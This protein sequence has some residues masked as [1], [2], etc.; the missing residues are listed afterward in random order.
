[1][2]LIA[3]RNKVILGSTALTD[4]E[5]DVIVVFELV[6]G[7]TLHDCE[8]GGLVAYDVGDLT[9]PASPCD[10]VCAVIKLDL[11][12]ATPVATE[13]E[14]YRALR[15]FLEDERVDEIVSL[16]L[17]EPNGAMVCPRAWL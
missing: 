15:A 1:M 9:V 8:V 2:I 17:W 6:H 12:D 4:R 5:K 10:Q 13:G 7:C 16:V 3:G 11:L 14:I